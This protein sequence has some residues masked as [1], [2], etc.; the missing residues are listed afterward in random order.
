[1][2]VKAAATVMTAVNA[3]IQYVSP[4]S[5]LFSLELLSSNF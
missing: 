2:A 5:R 3:A 4:R 1:M